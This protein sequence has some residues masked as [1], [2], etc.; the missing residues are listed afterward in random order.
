VRT[1]AQDF[2]KFLED[3]LLSPMNPWS[4]QTKPDAGPL[5]DVPK[6]QPPSKPASEPIGKDASPK[7]SDV[8]FRFL[9][10]VAPKK[11]APKRKNAWG[12]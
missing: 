1:K 9:K 2:L 3:G 12:F 7:V 6:S 10:K 5:G 11:D 4:Y 8:N